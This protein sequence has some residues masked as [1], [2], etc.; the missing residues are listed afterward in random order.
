MALYAVGIDLGGTNLR[1]ALVQKDGQIIE[2]ID[3]STEAALGPD[4]LTSKM[5]LA[6]EQ[7]ATK[8][9]LRSKDILG[10]GIGSP[11]PLSRSERKIFQTPHFPGFE[12]FP[13]GE[14]VE[15]LCG[16]KVLLDND[17]NCAA[18][19]EEMFG[20]AKGKQNF[21]LLTFGTGIGGGI[22]CDGRM[23]YGKSDGA[24]E[25]GH[26]LLYPDGERCACGRI[27]C[28][29]QYCSATAMTRRGAQALGRE[30][31]LPELFLEF[32]SGN[33]KARE[34]LSTIARDIAKAVGD[35]VN[36]FDPEMVVLGGGAFSTGGG[37]LFP[38]IEKY[39]PE[40]AFK[41]S[42]KNMKLCTS[43][44]KGNAG[45]LG[46]AAMVFRGSR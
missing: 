8:R 16:L 12:N 46:A 9:A 2:K 27:G 10:V 29:E 14:S 5:A 23:I 17:A 35:Y 4:A 36:I 33:P 38:L 30:I 6:I 45:V 1:V 31:K 22:F 39:L 44:L 43:S 34:C 19:G 40:E 28:F 24:G 26:I 21:V 11:G 20:A 25:L 7:L 13:L 15:K 41:S 37:P 3:K 32:E 18:A 42:L